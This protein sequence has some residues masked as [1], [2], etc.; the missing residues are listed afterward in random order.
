MIDLS[1]EQIRAAADKDLEAV[2]AVLAAL[3]PRIGQLANKYATNGGNRNHDLADELEQEGRIA[4]W[5]CIER[6]EGDSVAQF[7]T[8][9]DRSLKGVMDDKRRIET[10]QGVSEDTARRFERC[11]TVCAGD[12][13]EAE[14]EA[15]RADGALGR[16]RMT[17]DMAYA[18]RL[19]WQGVDY[20][21]APV[22]GS[23]GGGDGGQDVT[24]KDRI[25]DRFVGLPEDLAEPADI[26]RG[27]RKAVKFAV[28]NTLA[29]MGK[30]QAFVLRATFGID[31]VPPMDSDRE[32][33]ESLAI[34][35]KRV[36][37]IR[38]KGK[39]RFR[40]LYLAGAAGSETVNIAA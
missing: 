10:R 25:A 14:R 15:V 24:L 28:H 32:I 31:P 40:S 27:H 7:F 35:E 9:V 33:A 36:T 2:T 30:Q 1:V 22:P 20:L 5:Q 26:E 4:V 18:A 3:E 38:F 12:P 39:E 29:L 37:V 16:E 34:E 8:Y 21:D 6:F 17:P 13:Y 23:N 11:L 19:A